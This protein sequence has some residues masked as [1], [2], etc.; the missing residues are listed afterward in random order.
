MT[1]FTG[2]AAAL[3]RVRETEEPEKQP[4]TREYLPLAE[5]LFTRL[6]KSAIIALWRGQTDED[7]N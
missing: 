3:K 6:Q 7:K 5:N 1:V 2:E 4:L